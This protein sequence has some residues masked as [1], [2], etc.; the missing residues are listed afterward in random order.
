MPCL[1]LSLGGEGALCVV[2]AVHLTCSIPMFCGACRCGAQPEWSVTGE[3]YP[4][5]CAF[6]DHIRG[7]QFLCACP[8]R[9]CR[10]YSR[11]LGIYQ[12]GCG[13]DQVAFTWSGPEY[14]SLVLQQHG[15]HLPFDA[16]FLLRYQNFD[17]T[18]ADDA[19]YAGLMSPRD[20]AALPLL[21]RFV[22]ARA[23]ARSGKAPPSLDWNA[24]CAQCNVAMRRYFDSMVLLW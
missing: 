12:R 5:G 21:R 16:R 14:L 3:S 10:A 7:A 20:L 18:I 4:L 15:V 9:R 2:Q 1:C 23:A 19:A 22:R 11:P 6:S 24:T 13:L 8:D 17:C